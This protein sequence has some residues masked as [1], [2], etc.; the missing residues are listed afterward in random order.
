MYMRAFSSAGIPFKRLNY[1]EVCFEEEEEGGWVGFGREG[2]RVR[3][4]GF[5]LL[6]CACVCMFL[7]YSWC[8]CVL[9]RVSPVLLFVPACARVCMSECVIN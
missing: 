1:M 5:C 7:S 8:V 9:V 2:G 3:F 6:V 4:E